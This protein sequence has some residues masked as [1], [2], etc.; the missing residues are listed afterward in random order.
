MALIERAG[1]GRTPW[2]VIAAWI[3]AVAC[4]PDDRMAGSLDPNSEVEVVAQIGPAEG[5]RSVDILVVVDDSATM[6]EEQSLVG[7]SFAPLVDL[8]EAPDV[9]ASYRIA[10]TTTDV[11]NPL[12]DAAAAERGAFVSSS[13]SA[14]VGDFV[15]ADGRD[16]S[17]PGCLD[18]CGASAV[19]ILPTTTAFDAVP[20]PRPWIERVDC[21]TN[22]AG[23]ST[24]DALACIGPQGVAGCRFESPLEAMYQA[25]L[26]T[27]TPGDPQFG[28]LREHA[29][30]FVLL[31]TDGTDCSHR[32]E[33][34]GIFLPAEQGGTPVFWSDP[35]AVESTRA[36]CWNAGVRCEGDGD[37]YD[38]CTPTNASIDGEFGVPDEDA[39]LHPVSRY[40]ELLRQ[41][42]DSKRHI[43]TE[44]AVVVSL[45]SGVPQGYDGEMVYM[46]SAD[47]IEEAE[48]G[49]GP[50]CT[51]DDG[52]PSTPLVI[53]HP[54]VREKAVVNAFVGDE[55]RIHSMCQGDGYDETLAPLVETI[56][57]ILIPL[58]MPACVADLSPE[59]P[60]LQPRCTLRE[61]AP[62]VETG[63]VHEQIILPCATGGTLPDGE[64][65][66][67][68]EL[69]G[70]QGFCAERGWNLEFQLVRREGRCRHDG[71]RIF[72]TCSASL[73][74]DVDCPDL[75]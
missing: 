67:F 52:D 40:V 35:E 70:E 20:A 62:H 6:V 55:L 56:R 71:T 5:V 48:F 14:R 53:A 12:C 1:D 49:I 57:D 41:I 59:V 69:A 58:C 64:D 72:A 4:A 74:P 25:L 60:G 26:R 16:G 47:P 30:L 39:V 65:I 10:V 7:R 61:E 51:Y 37:P 43:A 32:D 24:A 63:E 54:P 21:T 19:E 34:E 31:L 2:G 8:L 11:G 44:P 9:G 28:F 15:S 45:V 17:A 46:R 23:I 27:M 73:E 22:L 66:C 42:E 36:V 13:C 3:V 18:H 68:V 38:A 33:H 29:T 75:P 50:G